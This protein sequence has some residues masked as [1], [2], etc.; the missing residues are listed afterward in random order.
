[1]L[2]PSSVPSSTHPTHRPSH[3]ARYL[4]NGAVTRDSPDRPR[5]ARPRATAALVITVF[6]R[7]EPVDAGREP[8]HLAV[9]GAIWRARGAFG[10]AAALTVPHPALAALRD[11]RRRQL[12]TQIFAVG[13]LESQRLGVAQQDLAG[14]STMCLFWYALRGERRA[15]APRPVASHGPHQTTHGSAVIRALLGA[16]DQRPH[17]LLA[18]PERVRVDALREHIPAAIPFLAPVVT[19]RRRP[20]RHTGLKKHRARDHTEPR[21]AEAPREP[22]SPCQ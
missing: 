17:P 11:M 18:P 2:P 20:R 3:R 21:G 10:G 9:A 1:M 15:P 7:P 19:R 13:R 8:A 16:L 6:Q 12:T 14:V 22:A 4:V 5:I